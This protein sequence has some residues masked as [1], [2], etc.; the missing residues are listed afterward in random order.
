MVFFNYLTLDAVNAGDCG[1]RGIWH[2]RT[3]KFIDDRIVYYNET[4]S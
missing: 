2:T 1:L 3:I 4:F